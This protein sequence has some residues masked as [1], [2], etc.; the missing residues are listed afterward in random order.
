MYD[1]DLD[2]E[3]VSARRLAFCGVGSVIAGLSVVVVAFDDKRT[4]VVVVLVLP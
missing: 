1:D 3:V 2:W 4:S